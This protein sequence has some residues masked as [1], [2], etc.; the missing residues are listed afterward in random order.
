[1]LALVTGC[2][3]NPIK[4]VTIHNVTSITVKSFSKALTKHNTEHGF[5][6]TRIHPL[7]I[8]ILVL[9]C[10]RQICQVK[11]DNDA[12]SDAKDKR[13]TISDGECRLNLHGA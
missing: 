13:F 4:S 10:H 7:N 2:C 5:S 1:M 6:V 8:L 11:P 9:L 3:Q 12:P